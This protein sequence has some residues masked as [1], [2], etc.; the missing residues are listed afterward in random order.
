MAKNYTGEA[1]PIVAAVVAYKA[2]SLMQK[3]KVID[4]GILEPGEVRDVT[5][6]LDGLA[7]TKEVTAILW[8]SADNF[9]TYDY[10]VFGG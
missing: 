9:A 3:V 4:L 2:N 1:K 10:S 6:D 8:D 5:Y 7:D